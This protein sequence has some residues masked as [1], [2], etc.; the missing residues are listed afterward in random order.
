MDINSIFSVAL[1]G[2]PNLKWVEAFMLC[3]DRHLRVT[4]ELC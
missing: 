4:N 1:T 3:F 2:S